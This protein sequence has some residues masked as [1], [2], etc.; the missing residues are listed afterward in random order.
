M[1]ICIYAYIIMLIILLNVIISIA[2]NSP[3]IFKRF[4]TTIRSILI[5]LYIF[6]IFFQYKFIKE[7]NNMSAVI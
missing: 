4:Y 7:M 3:L 1:H 2:L 6:F 5:T